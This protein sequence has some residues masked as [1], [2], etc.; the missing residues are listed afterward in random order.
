MCQECMKSFFLAV[1]IDQCILVEFSFQGCIVSSAIIWGYGASIWSGS[2][3]LNVELP[4]SV[5]IQNR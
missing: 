5:E 1:F 2:A 3:V 4:V